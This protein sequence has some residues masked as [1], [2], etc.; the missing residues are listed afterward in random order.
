MLQQLVENATGPVSA[1]QSYS[2]MLMICDYCLI[3]LAVHVVNM[4]D[5]GRQFTSANSRKIGVHGCCLRGY[6]V[7][8]HMSIGLIGPY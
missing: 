7:W 8:L 5:S 1:V 4:S 3:L 6:Q 2:S